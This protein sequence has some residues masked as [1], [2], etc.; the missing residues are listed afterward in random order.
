MNISDKGVVTL[1]SA[2]GGILKN[3]YNNV[4]LKYY[5]QETGNKSI[6]ISNEESANVGIIHHT[7]L[8]K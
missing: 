4:Q 3:K 6:S 2:L 8:L 5:I 7:K 1:K